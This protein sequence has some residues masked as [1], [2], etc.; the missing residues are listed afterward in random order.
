M[1]CLL[2]LSSFLAC[3]RLFLFSG[4]FVYRGADFGCEVE[5]LLADDSLVWSSFK[6]VHVESSGVRR[7]LSLII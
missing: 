5:H 1:I 2:V 4:L 3:S 7:P 6:L